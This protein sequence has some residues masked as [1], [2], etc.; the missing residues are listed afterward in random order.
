METIEIQSEHLVNVRRQKLDGCELSTVVI[1]KPSPACAKAIGE[2]KEKGD[3]RLIVSHDKAGKYEANY[4]AVPTDFKFD[5]GTIVLEVTYV[6][7]TN[8]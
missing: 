1:F 4:P 5:Y 6:K 2:W 8:D 7:Q 3:I